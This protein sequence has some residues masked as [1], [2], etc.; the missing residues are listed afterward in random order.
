MLIFRL[1]PG[2]QITASDRYFYI[3][4]KANNRIVMSETVRS[5]IR[6]IVLIECYNIKYV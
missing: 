4:V 2:G 1:F 3:P 6:D 5:E